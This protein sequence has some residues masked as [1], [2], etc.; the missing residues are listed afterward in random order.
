MW[1]LTVVPALLK[2]D[3]V[4]RA[5]SGKALWIQTQLV[6]EECDCPLITQPAAV[7]LRAAGCVSAGVR[8]WRRL[9]R[10]LLRRL[11]PAASRL[12]AASRGLSCSRC[13]AGPLS[14]HGRVALP[15]T[16]CPF[17]AHSSQWSGVSFIPTKFQKRH[18]EPYKSTSIVLGG[19]PER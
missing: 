6:R 13:C 3:S 17:L 5:P 1:D 2:M 15:L 9:G 12:P 7:C 8:G 10:L 19:N 11:G 18:T 4:C 16:T 14:A